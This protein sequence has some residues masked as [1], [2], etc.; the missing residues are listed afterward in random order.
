V[1]HQCATRAAEAAQRATA[2]GNEWFREFNE[3]EV[4][5]LDAELAATKADQRQAAQPE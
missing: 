1:S 3:A 5:R 2:E 4:A